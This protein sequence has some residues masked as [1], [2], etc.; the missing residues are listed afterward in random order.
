MA[1]YNLRRFACPEGLKAISGKHLLAFLKP[2][3]DYFTRRGMALPTKPGALDYEQLVAVLMDPVVDTPRDLSDGLFYVHE[4]ATPEGMDDLLEEARILGLA[5][6]DDPHPTPADVAVQVWLQDRNALERKHDEQFLTKPQS[7]EYF[8][9]DQSPVPDFVLP[10]PQAIRALEQELDDWFV[11]KKRGRGARVFVYPKDDGCWFLVRHGDPFKREGSLD[12]G[13][14]GSVYYRPEKFDVLVYDPRIGEI[15]MNARSK[16]EKNLYRRAFGRHLFGR[17]EFFPGTAKYT[18]EPL[19]VD[20]PSSLV[21]VDV[22]GMEWVRLVEVQFYWG[23]R[24]NEIEV[25][26]ADDVFAAYEARKARMPRRARIVR[27]RFRVKFTDAKAPRT[28]TI[29]P[30]NIA[31]Y[32]RDAD[33]MLIEQWLLN[34]GFIQ[35]G[36][37]PDHENAEAVLAGD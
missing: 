28:L 15:R 17:E 24:Q 34:R 11:E 36:E 33:S 19:R 30:S 22:E 31:K 23:G 3:G 18:L 35:V 1:T 13:K 2:H 10:T 9:T 6:D 26:K 12:D 37:R 7:F 29:C 14:P 32:Q 16:G 8:Q 21:C 27:A 5:L 4:M 20:G 25:R